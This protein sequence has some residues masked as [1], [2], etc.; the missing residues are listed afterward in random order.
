[1]LY[2]S[3]QRIS[4]FIET[5]PRLRPDPELFAELGEIEGEDDF[6][7]PGVVPLVSCPIGSWHK[8]AGLS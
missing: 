4:C 7:P 6:N 2:A 3:S 5:L 8:S 1:V